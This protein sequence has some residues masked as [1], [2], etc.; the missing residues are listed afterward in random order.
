MKLILKSDLTA[1]QKAIKLTEELPNDMELGR[2]IRCLI[3]EYK[4]KPKN[5]ISKAKRI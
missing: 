1:F 5:D 4:I 2:A 3:N